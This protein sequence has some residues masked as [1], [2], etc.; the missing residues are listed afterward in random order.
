MSVTAEAKLVT[1]NRL[2]AEAEERCV[3][4]TMLIKALVVK[5][6]H[7]GQAMDDLEEIEDQRAQLRAERKAMM[8]GASAS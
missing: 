7:V 6:E 1:L 4:Q 5:E 3:E 2:I 8:P